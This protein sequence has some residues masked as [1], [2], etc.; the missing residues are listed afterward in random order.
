[1]IE[2]T[3]PSCR[4][5]LRVADDRA[6]TETPCPTCKK[7]ALVPLSPAAASA[8]APQKANALGITSLVLAIASVALAPVS[9]A[10]W[11]VVIVTALLALVGLVV[12]IIA[13]ATAAK[14]NR[15]KAAGVAGLVISALSL[16]LHVVA[17]PV[18][19]WFMRDMSSW[20]DGAY[21]EIRDGNGPSPANPRLG[22]LRLAGACLIRTVTRGLAGLF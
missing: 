12:G 7:V 2:F 17:L 13:V 20:V 11:P 21:Q 22:P 15:G 16:V 8:P 19:I 18:L 10:A 14:R 6:G 4:A 9:I 5:V 3:C 1:M